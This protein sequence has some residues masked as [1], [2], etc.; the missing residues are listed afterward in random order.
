MLPIN[1]LLSLAHVV[2]LLR[3]HLTQV[4]QLLLSSLLLGALVLL[5]KLQ[6]VQ[7]DTKPVVVA[8]TLLHQAREDFTCPRLIALLF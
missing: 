7:V 6:D 4:M 8:C 2:V 1:T 5:E 3:Q